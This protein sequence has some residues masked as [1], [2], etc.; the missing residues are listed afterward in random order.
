MDGIGS[1]RNIVVVDLD[2]TRWVA[3][4]CVCASEEAAHTFLL[5]NGGRSVC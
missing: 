4:D 1:L 2:V 3:Q 5:A